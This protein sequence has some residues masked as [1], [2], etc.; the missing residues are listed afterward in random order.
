MPAHRLGEK[1]HK[2]IGFKMRWKS[3]NRGRFSGER[4]ALRVPSAAEDLAR[5]PILA[6]NGSALALDVLAHFEQLKQERQP[7]KPPSQKNANY[8]VLS[9]LCGSEIK[10]SALAK[11]SKSPSATKNTQKLYPLRFAK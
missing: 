7:H 10:M 2:G 6:N 11:M 3:G 5:A 1:S 8:A 4:E 9:S